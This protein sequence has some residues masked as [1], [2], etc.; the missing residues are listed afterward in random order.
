MFGTR[1]PSVFEDFNKRKSQ[2]W[3]LFLDV[4]LW[5]TVKG[6]TSSVVK[7]WTGLK[8]KNGNDYFQITAWTCS[9]GQVFKWRSE[10]RTKS[11]FHGLKCMLYNIQRPFYKSPGGGLWHKLSYQTYQLSKMARKMKRTINLRIGC[12]SYFFLSFNWGKSTNK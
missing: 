7:S 3:N 5:P 12:S 9:V 6:P 8:E 10:N 2:K 11:L 1:I 4:G